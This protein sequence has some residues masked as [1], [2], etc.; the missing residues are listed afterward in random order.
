MLSVYWLATGDKLPA[1]DEYKKVIDDNKAQQAFRAIDTHL[2]NGEPI[3]SNRA[4]LVKAGTGDYN[5]WEVKAPHRGKRIG[6]L[7][8]YCPDDWN[9]YV[10]HCVRKKSQELKQRWIDTAVGRVVSAIEGGGP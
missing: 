1:K 10:A 2:N 9:W 7:L 6:R 3:P 4:Q 8:C 5:I